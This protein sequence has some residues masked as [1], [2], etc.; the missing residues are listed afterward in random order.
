MLKKEE[1]MKV[2]TKAYSLKKKSLFGGGD[3]DVSGETERLG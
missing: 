2:W 1:N 3:E